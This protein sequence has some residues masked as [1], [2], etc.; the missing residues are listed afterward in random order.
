VENSDCIFCKIINKEIPCTFI[1]E[2]DE[3]I[4]VNDLSPKAPTHLLIIPKK[5]IINLKHLVPG[6]DDAI[7]AAM[8]NMAH[9][10]SKTLDEP[11]AFNLVSNNG[12]QA[13]QSVFHLHWH[14]L[15]GKK[16]FDA[17]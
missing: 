3:L 16:I 15:A 13:G 4:V 5:H 2:N 7:S 14:F 17:L 6:Q 10:L 11:A 1:R 12:K 8:L 9:E